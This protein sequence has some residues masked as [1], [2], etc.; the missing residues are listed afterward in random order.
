MWPVTSGG[1]C[2]YYHQH[3][4]DSGDGS[5]FLVDP[6]GLYCVDDTRKIPPSFSSL[7]FPLQPRIADPKFPAATI[8]EID[9]LGFLCS[10]PACS[11][12]LSR[13]YTA[14]IAATRTHTEP[15]KQQTK[16]EKKILQIESKQTEDIKIS[17]P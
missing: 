2:R 6:I 16:D 10:S 4:R 3:Q 15:N 1:E 13:P 14:S 12:S 17:K 11:H 8:P 5:A 7:L 9:S